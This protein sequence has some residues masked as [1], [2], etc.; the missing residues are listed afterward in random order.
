MIEQYTCPS[1][2]QSLEI[3]DS[4][5]EEFVC[6]PHCNNTFKSPNIPMF[7]KGTVVGDYIIEKRLGVGGMGEVYLAEQRSMMR[8][9]A[10]KILQPDLAEDSSYLE[11]FY[12]EVR[13]LAQIQHPNIVNAIETG[14]QDKICYF[15]M[16]YVKGMDLKQRLDE[17]GP[18][19][20]IDSLHVLLKISEALK[21]VWNKHKL[22]HRDI[23]PANII[24]TEENEVKLMDLGISKVI[25]DDKSTSLTMVGMMVGSPDYISPEQ[26]RAQ[27]DIDWRADMYS[28]GASFYHMLTG[29]V[30]FSAETSMGIVAAHLSDPIPDPRDKNP[31]ITDESAN[32]VGQMMQKKRNDRFQ[33]WDHAINAIKNAISKL[34]NKGAET[35]I[36]TAPDI[37]LQK[38]KAEESKKQPALNSATVQKIE[39]IK[40]TVHKNLINN[41]YARFIILVALLFITSIF[42]IKLVKESIYEAKVKHIN[43]QINRYNQS[44]SKLIATAEGRKKLSA[45]LMNIK[46]NNLEETSDWAENELNSLKQYAIDKNS[47]INLD[48]IK[49]QL[50]QLNAESYK[51][52]KQGEIEKAIQLWQNYSENGAFA[53]ELQNET[54]QAIK[55]LTDKAKKKKSPIE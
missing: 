39:K 18:M 29:E 9:V 32:I 20:E 4:D 6:C 38:K 19:S 36:T 44:K 47:S 41:L 30:P 7:P 25:S 37:T 40:K 13:T 8:P 34:S 35:T 43:S 48:D 28:L 27:E 12:R 52:E 1:C 49:N 2:E 16:S 45:L 22:I 26:A 10:L 3:D 50:D 55:Y 5:C 46:K 42:F 33:S 54:A 15:S 24:L 21:Y 17:S 23:K 14:C 11:R 51:L 53:K 31:Q